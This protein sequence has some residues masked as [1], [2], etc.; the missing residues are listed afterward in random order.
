M[1]CNLLLRLF[2]TANLVLAAGHY[3]CINNLKIYQT[4]QNEGAT[5]IIRWKAL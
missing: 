3:I 1:H 2:G 5:R 4:S